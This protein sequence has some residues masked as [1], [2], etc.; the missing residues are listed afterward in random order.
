MKYKL[1]FA[2]LVLGNLLFF[3]SIVFAGCPPYVVGS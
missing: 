2:F 1:I 3:G